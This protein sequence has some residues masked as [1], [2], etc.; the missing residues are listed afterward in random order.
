MSLA[1]RACDGAMVIDTFGYK[2]PLLM[3]MLN[4]QP[5]LAIREAMIYCECPQRK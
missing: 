2:A 1:N 4:R 5:A 3:L